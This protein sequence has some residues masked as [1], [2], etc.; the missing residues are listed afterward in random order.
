M[1]N[2]IKRLSETILLYEQVDSCRALRD[3]SSALSTAIDE[4]EDARSEVSDRKR[5]VNGSSPEQS[6]TITELLARGF[7]NQLIVIFE[8]YFDLT[9]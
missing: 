2:E 3:M 7:L 4:L 6:K 8:P 1:K 9:I 5:I